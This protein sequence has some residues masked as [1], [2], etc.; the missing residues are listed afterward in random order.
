LAT[1]IE[2][3]KESQSPTKEVEVSYSK[4]LSANAIGL[5]IETFEELFVDYINDSQNISSH[6]HQALAQNNLEKCA[7]EARLLKGMSSSMQVKE[8]TSELETLISSS[9]K[10]EMTNAIDR[11]DNVIEQISQ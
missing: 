4:E 8:F 10:N 3:E 6:I 2:T 9:D 11:I 7:K 1:D 5:D